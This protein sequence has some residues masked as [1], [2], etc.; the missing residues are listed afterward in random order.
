M[1][2]EFEAQLEKGSKGER[3][4]A[5][6]EG[7]SISTSR[8]CDLEDAQG[9]KIELKT[10]FYSMDS[11]PNFFMEFECEGK[12]GGPW[13]AEME[14][15][16]CFVYLF[17]DTKTA[18]WFNDVPALRKRLGELTVKMSRTW[19]ENNGWEASGYKVPREALQ[20][21]YEVRQYGSYT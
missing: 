12:M 7:L 19:V 6:A 2:Y 14:G 8:L 1:I 3:F 16:D 17:W 9:L 21:L 5:D 18:F 10:D 13:R 11:T 4:L 15:V 20:D